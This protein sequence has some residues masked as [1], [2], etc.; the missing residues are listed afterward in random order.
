MAD[1]KVKRSPTNQI[2][3]ANGE[4]IPYDPMNSPWTRRVDEYYAQNPSLLPKKTPTGQKDTPPHLANNFA[5][6]LLE[7]SSRTTYISDSPEA[8]ALSAAVEEVPPVAD[9]RRGNDEEE[10]IAAMNRMISVLQ[11]RVKDKK[12]G[13]KK[14]SGPGIRPSQPIPQVIITPPAVP[15]K[16]GPPAGP[17]EPI[18]Q[19]PPPLPPKPPMI[20]PPMRNGPQYRST[21]P[22][23]ASVDPQG[24]IKRVLSE[25]VFLTVE[26][27]FALAPEVRKYF[28]DAT[29]NK[30]VT[31]AAANILEE[32]TETVVEAFSV[33]QPDP[34]QFREGEHS[35]PLRTLDVVL[36][37]ATTVGGIL[38]GGCQVVILRGDIWEA[39][40]APMRHDK[41]MMMESANGQSNATM[42]LLPRICFTVGEVNLYCPVQVVANAPFECLLGRP[43]TC[44]GQ[45][46]SR[47]FLNGSMHITLTDPNTGATATLPT[48]PR[49]PPARKGFH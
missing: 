28:K 42:G 12:R 17:K 6:N 39:L 40:G 18:P 43:F 32:D 8:S 4:G 23:T 33:E 11:T 31:P 47:E 10:D 37:G 34:T 21:A 35:L 9:G 15:P 2:I 5:A 19:V 3:L 26:E 46:V 36:N 41:V 7:V 30:K 24:V 44:L 13:Q 45:A 22:I 38:D 16:M 27:L 1:G 20:P 48:T 14:E 25:K 49:A 29:T